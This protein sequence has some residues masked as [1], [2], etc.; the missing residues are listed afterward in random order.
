M[1]AARHYDFGSTLSFPGI[2]WHQC[3]A[4]SI[5]SPG[6]VWA[7]ESSERPQSLKRCWPSRVVICFSSMMAAYSAETLSTPCFL[8][9]ILH[10][11]VPTYVLRW[12]IRHEDNQAKI[13]VSTDSPTRSCLGKLLCIRLSSPRHLSARL[14]MGAKERTVSLRY[15]E[16]V[17]AEETLLHLARPLGYQF[18]SEIFPSSASS[19]TS[20]FVASDRGVF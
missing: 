4:A 13:S 10:L 19:R 9:E 18:I 3:L 6:M 16:R 5:M 12:S 17:Q 1:A 2:T 20:A 11:L 14:A 8:C 7:T 15:K